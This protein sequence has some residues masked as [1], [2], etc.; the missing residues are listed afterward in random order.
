M[1][2][3][4]QMRENMVQTRYCIQY[5]SLLAINIWL[6]YARISRNGRNER[7]EV[8]LYVG[9]DRVVLRFTWHINVSR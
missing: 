1:V 7:G 4:A 8:K 3:K 6:S 5:F 2:G 9:Q